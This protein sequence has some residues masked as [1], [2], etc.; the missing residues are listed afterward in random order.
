MLK[1]PYRA[2]GRGLPGGVF[3]LLVFI[4]FLRRLI[5]SA[6]AFIC[7]RVSRSVARGYLCDTS[8]DRNFGDPETPDRAA[9]CRASGVPK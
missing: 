3:S 4:R 2:A 9:V 5:N 6:L 8:S 1:L 7:S